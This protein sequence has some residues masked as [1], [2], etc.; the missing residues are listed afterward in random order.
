MGS[1]AIR[2]NRT[3]ATRNSQARATRVMNSQ[4]TK[5]NRVQAIREKCSQDMNNQVQNTGISQVQATTDRTQVTEDTET[6]HTKDAKGPITNEQASIDRPH[7][8]CHQPLQAKRRHSRL[9]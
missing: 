4:A 6:A 3:E 5:N 7:R 8:M 1:L 2:P 9:Q